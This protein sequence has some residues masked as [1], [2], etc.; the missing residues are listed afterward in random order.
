MKHV[1][2]I[3]FVC[4]G[5]LIIAQENPAL[6]N[7]KEKKVS[8][9]GE[10]KGYSAADYGGFEYRS[11][12]HTTKD[13]VQIAI[14]LFLP[15]KRKDGETFPTILYLTRYV[16]SLE[17]KAFI[18]WLKSPLLGQ[19][20][21]KEIKF[22]TSHGYACMIVD[23]RG[24][25]ASSASRD[26]DFTD[27]EVHDVY[28]IMDLIVAQPWSNGKIG[29]TGVS[30]VGTTAE[31]IIANQHPAHKA[32]IP[33]S[34]IFDL[35]EDVSF[36]GGLRQGPFVKVWGETTAALDRSDIGFVSKMA[37]RFV[38]GV[39]PVQDD[40]KRVLLKKYIDGHKDNYQVHK[41]ILLIECRDELHR[42]L[43][44]PIDKYSVHSHIPAIASAH[45]AIYR[46]GGY[47]DGALGLSLIKGLLNTPN[48]ERVLLGPWDHGPH[49]YA[50]PFAPYPSKQ[51]DV[52]A[53]MLRFF[54]YH[55]KGIDNGIQNEPKINFFTIGKEK[56]DTAS[57]W[58][59]AVTE[60]L[61]MG[62][63]DSTLQA[64][65][66]R[67]GRPDSSKRQLLIDYNFTSGGGARWNSLTP[68]FRGE[69]H[70]N[71]LNWGNKIASCL[72]YTS[73]AF[74]KNL[75]IT[76]EV[77][78]SLRIAS[79][80]KDGAVLVYLEEV[81]P[82]G[83]VYYI[84]EGQLRLKH[85]KVTDSPAYKRNGPTHSFTQADVQD[86][87]I[88]VPETVTIVALPISYYLPQGSRLRISIAGADKGH[89]DEVTDKPTRYTIYSSGSGV[90]LP[91]TYQ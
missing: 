84:T 45:T 4:F 38:R 31:L 74:D 1:F 79:D 2:T 53:E 86:M 17:G 80:A 21:E 44:K 71:Y 41:D 81:K 87:P 75:T 73:S 77:I 56:W 63:V 15:K 57:V 27:E 91:I 22:F 11:F 5:S 62:L 37:K 82:D 6:N 67:Q 30:Y 61:A 34:A 47:Y 58:P 64:F 16:R 19:I 65:R 9:L 66:W 72:S 52:Y 40:K 29:T 14:D 83:S 88:G 60:N 90:V 23:A 12:Y 33:R 50:S 28:E 7:A 25:G 8:R 68:L 76:G 55:L 43:Q 49:D 54:D 46:I 18:K 24:S 48:T 59:P 13:S 35:Y 85:R 36:P 51:F 89:S 26:M 42:R 39:N 70:T 3:L 78:F 32:A 69:K 10:Y 20:G